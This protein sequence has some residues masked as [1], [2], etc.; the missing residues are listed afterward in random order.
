[1][2]RKT[3]STVNN[4]SNWFYSQR[5]IIL[6][7]ITALMLVAA[8]LVVIYNANEPTIV[9]P[10]ASERVGHIIKAT[11]QEYHIKPSWIKTNRGDITASIPAR[12]HFL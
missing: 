8:N 12:F 9:T 7:S 1:M 11:L 6:L 4:F 3:K 5:T 2:K 10:S